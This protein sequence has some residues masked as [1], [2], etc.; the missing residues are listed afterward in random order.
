MLQIFQNLTIIAIN[1]YWTF[2]LYL[3]YFTYIKTIMIVVIQSMMEFIILKDLQVFIRIPVM[4]G[5]PDYLQK[6]PMGKE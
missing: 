2:I 3:I 5:S 1:V 4:E 6:Y